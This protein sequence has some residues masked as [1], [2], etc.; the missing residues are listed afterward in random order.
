MSARPYGTLVRQ[1]DGSG[2]LAV[3]TRR[4][5][6]LLWD[7]L[8]PTGVSWVG[9]YVAADA[10]GQPLPAGFEPSSAGSLVLQACRNKPACSP[11]GLNGACGRSFRSRR[12]L[13]V[14]D[15]ASLGAGYIACDA[16]DRSEVV[17]PLLDER[18][19]C[20]GV[21]DLDSYAVEAF[22]AADAAGLLGVLRAAGVGLS[23]PDEPAEVV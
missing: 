23:A 16:L 2:D 13:V 12:S 3:R 11:I 1:L 18:G 6:D 15:V 19:Q 5:I 21:L 7:H 8:H 22:S 14:R 17:V 9:V 10:E 20:R 4:L